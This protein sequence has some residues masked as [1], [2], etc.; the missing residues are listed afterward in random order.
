MTIAHTQIEQASRPN[1]TALTT[2]WADQNRPNTDKPDTAGSVD[3]ATSA[4][5]MAC[6][7]GRPAPRTPVPAQWPGRSGTWRQAPGHTA[8]HSASHKNRAACHPR[9][10]NLSRNL[11]KLGHPAAVL[12][13]NH[14]E[15]RLRSG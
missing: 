3:W 12:G 10:T 11:A 5:F 8:E 13:P 14:S 6:P 9:P 2:M 4:G 7:L 15:P 1:I